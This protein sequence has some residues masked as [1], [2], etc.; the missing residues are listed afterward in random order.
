M[1]RR[2]TIKNNINIIDRS[3]VNLKDLVAAR[4]ISK[5][6]EAFINTYLSVVVEYIN[7]SIDIFDADY[8]REQLE[9]LDD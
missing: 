3:L 8:Y 9:E 1:S 5:G 2:R 4:K 6:Q 7:K